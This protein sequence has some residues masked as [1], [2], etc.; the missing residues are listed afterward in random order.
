MN[1]I[2]LSYNGGKDCLVMLVIFLC[3]IYDTRHECLLKDETLKLNTIFVNTEE[4]FKEMDEFLRYSVEEYQLSFVQL[5]DE[6]KSGFA[7]YLELNPNIRS[8]IVGI[9]R[10][11]PYGESLTFFEQTDH[12]W[13]SFLRI[14]PVLNWEYTEI[15]HFIRST[16]IRYCQLYDMGYTS[17]GGTHNTVPNPY[18]LKDGEFLPAWKLNENDKERLSRI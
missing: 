3:V 17:I 8:I 7:H 5:K 16:N 13:P 10:I 9:R 14:H 12:N 2:A 4:S 11:D 15:W 1:E 18:L 6:L